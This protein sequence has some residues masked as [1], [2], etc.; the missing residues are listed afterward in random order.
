MNDAS[1]SRPAGDDPE[2]SLAVLDVPGEGA[3][4]IRPPLDSGQGT[5]DKNLAVP[6]DWIS[7]RFTTPFGQRIR[8]LFEGVCYV[9]SYEVSKAGVQ[10]WHVLSIGHEHYECVKKRQ[11][12]ALN[13]KGMASWSK[14]N[15]G[16]FLGGLSYTLKSCDNGVPG[17]IVLKSDDWPDYKYDTWVFHASKQQT[18][19]TDAKPEREMKKIRDWQLTYNNLVPQCLEFHRTQ[20]LAV[21]AG[22]RETLRLMMESTKWR[23]SPVMLREG[24]HAF[25]EEDFE[26]RKGKRPKLDM[27]W[28]NPRVR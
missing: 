7:W 19:S 4:L 28:Y 8:Q 12:R 27:S 10:H 22:L 14:K 26:F 21:E 1:P 15:F 3:Y 16:T 25:F 9:A 18:I 17:N 23:P 24:V 11:Q 13:M 6:T 2:M 20:G 5:K